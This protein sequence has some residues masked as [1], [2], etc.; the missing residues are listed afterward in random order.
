MPHAVDEDENA[1]GLTEE[2][3]P[4]MPTSE[5]RRLYEQWRNAAS[6][7]EQIDT[8]AD[9]RELRGLAPWMAVPAGRTERDPRQFLRNL[10]DQARS[11]GTDEMNAPTAETARDT[12]PPRTARTG[13]PPRYRASTDKR[14]QR[15]RTQQP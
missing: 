15:S 4:N 6:R 5:E 10:R 8:D 12:L 3:D 7:G 14:C 13:I 9:D 2:T 11:D 1:E